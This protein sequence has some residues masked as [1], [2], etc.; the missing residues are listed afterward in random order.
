[1]GP[2]WV[3]YRRRSQSIYLGVVWADEAPKISGNYT[4]ENK[5]IDAKK[6]QKRWLFVPPFKYGY[7]GYP[8]VSFRG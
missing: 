4:P 1:M 2:W 6:I 3:P 5:H 8:V 7:F